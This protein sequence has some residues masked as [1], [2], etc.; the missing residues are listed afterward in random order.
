MVDTVTLHLEELRERFRTNV[1]DL[2][3]ARGY[4]QKKL[5]LLAQT[6]RFR[7]SEI[8]NGRYDPSFE[9]I[10]RMSIALGVDASELFRPLKASRNG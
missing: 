9:T 10:V 8:E 5:A 6:N 3:H 4:T 1:S 2:R 7:V